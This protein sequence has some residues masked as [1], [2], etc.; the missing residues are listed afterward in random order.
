LATQILGYGA[1]IV[2]G[3]VSGF[4]LRNWQLAP[5]VQTYQQIID[6]PLDACRVLLQPYISIGPEQNGMVVPSQIP[7][8]T[9]PQP[10][11]QKAPA[12]KGNNGK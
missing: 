10:S 5:V 11:Q 6:H 8:Q 9:A 4:M 1:A 2:L 12:T 3:L 7:Q